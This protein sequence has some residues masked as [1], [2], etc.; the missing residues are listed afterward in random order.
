MGLKPDSGWVGPKQTQD[1][2]GVVLLAT[3]DGDQEVRDARLAQA[4]P[5]RK[6]ER[7]L[8]GVREPTL[9]V[10]TRVRVDTQ[11]FSDQSTDRPN[12]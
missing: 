9:L 5:I 10:G 2:P 4:D 11:P 3:Y 6:P 12:R 1:L 8:G 7:V